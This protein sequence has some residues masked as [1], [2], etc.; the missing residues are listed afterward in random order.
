MADR[1]EDLGLKGG[2]WQGALTQESRPGRIILTHLGETAAE[3][4]ITEEAPGYWRVAT[5][6]PAE[7]ISEGIQTFLLLEDGGTG[8][9]PASP[10]ADRLATLTLLAGSVLDEDIQAE[11][12]LLKSEIELLKREFRRMA[13]GLR[14][15][16]PA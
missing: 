8:S 4:R 11:I 13:A 1:F 7:R 5:P 2:I 10:G 14:D 3:A 15:S 16:T 9:E 6:I 12:A